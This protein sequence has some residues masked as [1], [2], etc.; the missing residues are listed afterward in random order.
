ML[1]K[2]TEINPEFPE[3]YFKKKSVFQYLDFNVANILFEQKIEIPD[4]FILYPDSS[5][6]CLLTKYLK[7]VNI[8]C[9]ISTDFQDKL[10]NYCLINNKRIFLFGDSEDVLYKIKD[11]HKAICGVYSGYN[12]SDEVIEIINRANPDILFVGLGA[13]RQEKWLVNNYKYI[14]CNLIVAVGGWFQYLAG[15]KK[16]APLFIRRLRLEWLHKNIVEW[17]RV[18]KRYLKGIPL[19]YYRALTNKISLLEK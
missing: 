1:L 13:G 3:N 12:Y 4:S 16:R 6:V 17:K 19:F 11:K 15:N 5:A 9:Y 10:F 2:L 18:S 8:K 7:K 14:N